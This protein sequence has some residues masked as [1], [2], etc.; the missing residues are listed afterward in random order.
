MAEVVCAEPRRLIHA[1]ADRDTI[2]ALAHFR[3]L[4][5]HVLQEA[6]T[7]RD[8]LLTEP[9]LRD[10]LRMKLGFDRSEQFHVI[11][12]DGHNHFIEGRTHWTGTVD[13]VTCYIRE[14][15]FCAISCGARGI[16]LAHNHP[17]GLGEPSQED[18]RLTRDFVD[19]TRR[20]EL[21]VIDHW[22]VT[23]QDAYSFRALGL[24]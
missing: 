23:R 17:S 3:A 8:I 12:V 4:H 9:A 11:Y 7:G 2:R 10:Y 14:V 20:L 24:M 1:G 15:I 16:I 6:I 13:A 5:E 18:V 21:S 19:A 22:I